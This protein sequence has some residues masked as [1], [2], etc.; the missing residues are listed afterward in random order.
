M[1]LICAHEGTYYTSSQYRIWYLLKM[2]YQSLSVLVLYSN[3]LH[4]CVTEPTQ[5]HMER[6]IDQRGEGLSEICFFEYQ[7]M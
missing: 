7:E 5:H 4:L 6:G 3:R 1:S 2:I